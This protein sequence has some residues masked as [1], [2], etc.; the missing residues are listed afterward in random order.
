MKTHD[1][2][3]EILRS[4]ALDDQEVGWLSNMGMHRLEYNE[5]NWDIEVDGFGSI[6]LSHLASIILEIAQGDR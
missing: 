5:D 1:E 4:E 6:D 3:I 2:V